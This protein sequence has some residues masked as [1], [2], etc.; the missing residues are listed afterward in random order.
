MAESTKGT[1]K[2]LKDYKVVTAKWVDELV[3][4]LKNES[5]DGWSV[6]AYFQEHAVTKILLEKD[7]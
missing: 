4:T 3:E 2:N 1:P 7:L 6:V 5:K